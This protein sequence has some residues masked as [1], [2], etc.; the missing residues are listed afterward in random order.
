MPAY[1]YTCTVYRGETKLFVFR[2]SAEIIF[3]KICLQKYT[4]ITKTAA[5]FIIKK[6]KPV[7]KMLKMKPFL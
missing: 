1:H 2:I 3:E 4:K 7:N 6:A 5:K